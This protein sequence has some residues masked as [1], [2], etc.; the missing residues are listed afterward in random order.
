MIVVKAQL[1]IT[2]NLPNAPLLV[3][4]KDRSVEQMLPI[5]PRWL[6]LFAGR[7]KIYLHASI[8]AAGAI[9]PVAVIPDQPW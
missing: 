8:D 4:N 9:V 2:S 3:Y 5:T 7:P 6:E 1:P